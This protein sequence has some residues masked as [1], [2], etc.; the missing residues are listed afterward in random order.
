MSANRERVIGSIRREVL[1]HILI[2]NESHAPQ[3]LSTYQQHCNEHRPHRARNQ[4]PPDIHRSPP[5]RFVRDGSPWGS[6][7]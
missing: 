3:V 7:P 6:R 2:T 4:L 5:L 1:G